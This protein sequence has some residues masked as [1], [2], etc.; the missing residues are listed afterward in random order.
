[1]ELVDFVAN[2]SGIFTPLIYK[3]I[4]EMISINLFRPLPPRLNP[5]GAQFDPEEDEPI[6]EDAWP[7]I[8]I[9]Y[10]L[11][12]KFLE[13]PDFNPTYAK[14]YFSKSFVSNL[15][16]LFGCEDPRERDYLKMILHRIYGKFLSIRSFI[17]KSIKNALLEFIYEFDIPNGIYELLEILGSIINGFSIPLKEEHVNFLMDALLP[18]HRSKSL[19]LYHSQLSFCIIQ[20][21]QKDKNLTY[22]I[23]KKLFKY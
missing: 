12:L 16:Y 5:L 2:K 23:I 8:Q 3:E 15:I 7:H 21:I 14:H 9:V 6:L 4:S 17:R 11:F 20:Y 19:P 18:L 22:P 10:E 13:A 1:L